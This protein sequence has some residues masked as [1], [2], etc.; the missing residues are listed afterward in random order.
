ME[1]NLQELGA[2]IVRD[3][4]AEVTCHEP[5]NHDD[6]AIMDT[7]LTR[8]TM[9]FLVKNLFMG[10]GDDDAIES[11]VV[12]IFQPKTFLRWHRWSPQAGQPYPGFKI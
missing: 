8:K 4:G 12:L 5:G 3:R 6:D 11:G 7:M 9:V 1:D 10:G 2:A